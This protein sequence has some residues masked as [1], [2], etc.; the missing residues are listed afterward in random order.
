MLSTKQFLVTAAFMLSYFAT[1]AFG[2]TFTGNTVLNGLTVF[3][4]PVTVSTDSNLV[5]E[6]GLI[7]N[8]FNSITNRGGLYICET[9]AINVG[10][11]VL[12]A[13]NI[14]NYGTFVVD[15][16]TAL[17]GLTFK[18]AGIK[19]YNAGEFFIYGK[20]PLITGSVFRIWALSFHNEGL[21]AFYQN[22]SSNFLSTVELGPETLIDALHITNTGTICLRSINMHARVAF[23]GTGCVDVGA[24]ATLTINNLISRSVK[25]QTI[26]MS[27]ETSVIYVKSL[28]GLT[29]LTVRGFGNTNAIYF[30]LPVVYYTYNTAS[31]MLTVIDGLNFIRIDIGTGYD[32]SQ[33][34]RVTHHIWI[35]AGI[36]YTGAVPDATR[37]AVCA[38]CVEVPDCQDALNAQTSVSTESNTYTNTDLPSPYTTTVTAS[39]TTETQLISFYWTTDANGSS[40]PI[41]TVYT[42]TGSAAS[43]LDAESKTVASSDASSVVASSE[44]SSVA[45]SVAASSDASVASPVASSAVASSEVSSSASGALS[46]YTTTK[47]DASTTET[48]VV[49]DYVTTDNNGNT[50]TL[51]STY[52]ITASQTPLTTYTTT[53]V[54][55]GTTS[56]YVVCDYTTTDANGNTVTLVSSYPCI[57]EGTATTYTRTI[58]AEICTSTVV[59]CTCTS[60]KSNGETVSTLTTY[61]ATYT[62]TDMSGDSYTT[63]VVV[64]G[65]VTEVVEC[66]YLTTDASGNTYTA[67][68][69]VTETS[70]TTTTETVCETC[71]EGKAT[72]TNAGKNN[73][74][75]NTVASNGSNNG[76][77]TASEDTTT[78]ITNVAVST[79]TASP[80]VE[81]QSASSAASTKNLSEY[82]GSASNMVVGSWIAMVSAFVFL[83]F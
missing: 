59:V 39:G 62:P 25:S 46:Y 60:T 29:S 72:A 48:L 79:K 43:S 56:V 30:Q 2:K 26:Y 83:L 76:A 68:S 45:S 10:M 28:L 24:Y 49:S 82:E 14:N 16:S 69:T 61:P 57:T 8:F 18:S 54:V 7:H 71:T 1:F 33:M 42:L 78:T 44:A 47:S 13:G 19:F 40:F 4:L 32:M 50:V 21:M 6:S 20:K 73:E 12:A 36:T 55:D 34:F 17:T 35:G 22:G 3:I 80:V 27:D 77:N 23:E 31:G 38:E 37:P 81:V 65:T 15:D 52:T 67:H 64:G 74:N 63:T 53:V 51:E 41:E 11:T 66:D 75:T 9:K 70:L 58:T 5:I